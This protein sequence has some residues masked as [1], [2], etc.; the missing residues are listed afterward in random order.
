AYRV[1]Y[2]TQAAGGYPSVCWRTPEAAASGALDRGGSFPKPKRKRTRWGRRL[3]LCHAVVLD[4]D[5]GAAPELLG[6]VHRLSA[7]GGTQLAHDVADVDFHG[8]LAHAKSICDD[9]VGLALAQVRQH[10]HLARRE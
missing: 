4:A 2:A 8:A 10:S 1:L 6:F 3:A 5:L 9:L 7:V